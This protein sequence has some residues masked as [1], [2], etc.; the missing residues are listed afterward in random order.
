M[1]QSALD[2][3]ARSVDTSWREADYA[4]AILYLSA[5]WLTAEGSADQAG[6]IKS[7]SFGP[8]SVSYGSRSTSDEAL[9]STQY[10]ERFLELRRGNFGAPVL[11]V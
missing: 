1:V 10:G 9:A 8:I 3:A 7:E 2:E 5:H 4:D 6:V 11:V